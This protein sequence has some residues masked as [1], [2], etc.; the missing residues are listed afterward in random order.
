MKS[1]ISRIVVLG[2]SL[3][4]IGCTS[5]SD[6]SKYNFKQAINNHLEKNCIT[7]STKESNFPV[8]ILT[9]EALGKGSGMPEVELRR[10]EK[11]D[12]EKTRQYAALTKIGFLSAN[13]KTKKGRY[14]STYKLITY[15]LTENGRELFE[16][17]QRMASKKGFC[18]ARYM[19]SKIVNYSEPSEAN[20][21]TV[22]YVNFTISP[23]EVSDWASD[24]AILGA[25]PSL[26]N[27]LEN[28]QSR[29]AMLV[30]MSDGWV[31]EKE[32]KK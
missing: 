26:T 13:E 18:A 6:A 7:I 24:Q 5:P 17:S 14:G 19:V 4:I 20:G 21:Y 25:F 30:L 29:T 10:L 2:F 28:N 1:Q 22:S 3:F 11:K 31:Y 32:I 23:H 27:E 8:E 12:I 15:T 16:Q 9:L